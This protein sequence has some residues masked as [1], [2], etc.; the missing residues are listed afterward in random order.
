MTIAKRLLKLICKLTLFIWIVCILPVVILHP[1]RFNC[2]GIIVTIVI[3]MLTSLACIGITYL[4]F[5]VYL[6]FFDTKHNKG[7]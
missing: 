5:L 3:S 4:A 6:H 2:T 1:D 7:N